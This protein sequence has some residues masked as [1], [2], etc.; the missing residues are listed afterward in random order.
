MP[1]EGVQPVAQQAAEHSGIHVTLA[2]E[3][4]TR[5][6]GFP[7]TNTLIMSW[8]AMAILIVGAFFIGRNLKLMPGRFQIF[9]E[10][11]YSLIEDFVHSTL[12]NA[13]WARR[14]MPLLLT[15]FLFI[16]LANL[17]EFTPGVGSVLVYHGAESAPF[18]HGANADLN[19]TLALTI[20]AVFTIEIAGIMSLGFF[21]YAGKFITF[22]GHSISERIINFIVGIIELVSELSRFVSFSFRLFGNIFAGQ[23]LIAVV[24]FFVPYILPSGLMA[25]EMFVGIVQAAV[26]ALLTLFFVKMAIAEPHG[27][28]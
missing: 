15:M 27:S 23:V 7:I 13:L 28:H 11:L 25:F 10:A 9:V 18:L 26:F 20:I 6:L 14:L 1:Q 22:A 8:I 16:A 3:V 17:L 21:R 2:P 4:I 5:F 24:S 12:E 19:N